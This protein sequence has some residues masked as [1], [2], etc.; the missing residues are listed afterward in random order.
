MKP[1]SRLVPVAVVLMSAALWGLFWIP[2]RAFEARGLAP[3]WTTLA[4]FLVPFVL[5]VPFALRRSLG[6]QPTG[7]THVTTGLLIGAAFV[8]YY[9]SLLLTEVVRALLLFYITPIWGTALEAIVLKRKVS[10]FRIFALVLGVLGL[11]VV[12]TSKGGVPVPQNAGDWMALMSGF[13]FA[14]GTLRIRALPEMDVF[15]HVFSFFL[16]GGVFALA[17]AFLPVA[18]LR[19]A[20]DWAV[21]APLVPWL[22]A[23]A[24]GF[25]IPVM[26]GL[27][28]GAKHMDPGR[29]GILFQMEAVVGIA[30]AAAWANEPF[31]VAEAAATVLIVSASVLDVVASTRQT[32]V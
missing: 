27:L 20:P 4:Q 13:L 10:A 25:L 7:I 12:L 3:S 30:S 14:V 15:E 5:L 2:L 31:G 18:G 1:S 8:L 24:A 32:K 17:M 21:L 11:L 22:L 28:W 29:L 23:M 19:S 16:Y 9:Q 26:W 6:N